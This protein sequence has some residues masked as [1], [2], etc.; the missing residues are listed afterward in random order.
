[1]TTLFAK[2]NLK[3]HR[4]IVILNAPDGFEAEL[5]QLRD[6]TIL[7]AIGKRAKV[8]FAMAFATTAT[9]RDAASKALA[10]AADGDAIIWIAYPKKSSKRYTCD[11]DRDSG[12]EVLGNAGF[13]TVR[14]VAIDEDWSALRFRRVE[15][16]KSM[17]RRSSHAVSPAGKS[18]TSAT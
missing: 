6:V 10:A 7:R 3:D 15:Y 4:E 16:V 14:M 2:L 17:A 8:S 9:A 12:W 5:E 1:M 18:R 13:E 11:F